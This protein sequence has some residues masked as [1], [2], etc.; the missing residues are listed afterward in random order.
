MRFVASCSCKTWIGYS[1]EESAA[2]KAGERHVS[3]MKRRN[4]PTHLNGPHV[5]TVQPDEFPN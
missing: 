2:R 3:E 4:V 1:L 5:L